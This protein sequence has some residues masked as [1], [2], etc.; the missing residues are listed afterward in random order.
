MYK[1]ILNDL[2]S[3]ISDPNQ[4]Y[5]LVETIT[6]DSSIQVELYIN[7]EKVKSSKYGYFPDSDN[8]V[9][10]EDVYKSIALDIFHIGLRRMYQFH[11]N[12]L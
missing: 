9:F 12:E 5:K 11:K 6:E 3:K 4:V 2:L 7:E 8:S 1:E 10:I